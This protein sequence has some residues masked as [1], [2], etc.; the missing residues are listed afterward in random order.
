MRKIFDS[1]AIDHAY[2]STDSTRIHVWGGSAYTEAIILESNGRF[3]LVDAGEDNDYP[4]GTDSRY[5]LRPGITQGAGIEDDLVAYLERLGVTPDNLE[6]L[7]ITHSHS[8]HAGGADTIIERF[9]PQRV[10]VQEYRDEYITD[11]AA[12]WD[13]LYVYD[14]LIAAAETAGVPIVQRFDVSAPVYP[15]EDSCDS[16]I[17]SEGSS[18]PGASTDPIDPGD[19]ID[20]EGP[21]D[22][23]EPLVASPIFNLGAMQIEIMNYGDDYK[24]GHADAN[25]ACLGV[26]VTANG[27]TAFLA[28]DVNNN[29]GDEDR[30]AEQLGKIDILKMGHHGV[31]GSNTVSYLRTL[32]PSVLIQTGFLST[33]PDAIFGAITAMNSRHYTA[34]E[35]M[36]KDIDFI[37]MDLSGADVSCSL[38]T[39]RDVQ[40]H[41]NSGRH[42]LNYRDGR[43]AIANGWLSTND[44]WHYFSH[45][46][47]AQES[48]W[49]MSGKKWYWVN[50]RGTMVRGWAEIGGRWYYFDAS[51][52]MKT[53][54]QKIRGEWYY[55]GSDG[56]M[57]TGWLRQD[58]KWY[59]LG[60]SGIMATGWQQIE[61]KRY[62]FN[63]SG[64]MQIGWKKLSG[65]WYYLNG[66][67]AMATGWKMLDGVWYYLRDS[68]DMATGWQQ[69]GQKWYYLNSSG[70]MQV[71]WKK[72]SG[73]WYY[74]NGSGAMATGW[75]KLDGV[76]YYLKGSGA[77]ATGWQEVDGRWYYLYRSGVM[78]RNLWIQGRYWVGEDGGM[79]T[80]SYV[81]GGRYYVDESGAWVPGH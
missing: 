17:G 31:S 36:A 29:D 14:Q 68:G 49:V 75:K 30:L 8:D 63:S 76:W 12:L 4:D 60:A 79:A 25:D 33:T 77:M 80:A 54:W 38:D 34:E 19:P 5:P 6:F 41:R 16:L 15:W 53:G 7:I 27:K 43:P 73:K 57:A 59:H 44:Q 21:G 47:Y 74:L 62:Y 70:A 52:A 66:S 26:K 22:S 10:Y 58:G 78:A 56:A 9:K 51:G 67:G 1:T 50:E 69:V 48:M 55:L 32:S 13:N 18:E 40:L 2:A 39:G 71:G 81:D 45:D 65:K 72:L 64:A 20:P 23:E 37:V 61:G 46:I 35:A 28:G 42:I 3:G 24:A 11:P